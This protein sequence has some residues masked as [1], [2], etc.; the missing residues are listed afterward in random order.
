MVL[1]LEQSKCLL[2]ASLIY[3]VLS[4]FLQLHD[5]LRLS[6]ATLSTRDEAFACDVQDS[7]L[8]NMLPASAMMFVSLP[9]YPPRGQA[10]HMTQERVPPQHLSLSHPSTSTR[11]TNRSLRNEWGSSPDPTLSPL[12]SLSGVAATMT[13]YPAHSQECLVQL[14]EMAD[15]DADVTRDAVHHTEL[16]PLVSWQLATACVAAALPLPDTGEVTHDAAMVDENRALSPTMLDS[17]AEAGTGIQTSCCLSLLD[18]FGSCRSLMSLGSFGQPSTELGDLTPGEFAAM[19]AVLAPDQPSATPLQAL[20]SCGSNL[21]Q[22]VYDALTEVPATSVTQPSFHPIML[23]DA[24][25]S[26]CGTLRRQEDASTSL[27]IAVRNTDAPISELPLGAGWVP[28]ECSLPDLQ[29]SPPALSSSDYSGESYHSLPAVSS[30]LSDARSAPLHPQQLFQHWSQAM[31]FH[32]AAGPTAVPPLAMDQQGATMAQAGSL[33]TSAGPAIVAQNISGGR[34]RRGRAG[35]AAAST[36]ALRNREKQKQ[37]E[38][39]KRV[40]HCRICF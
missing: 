25:G 21:A 14:H 38:A 9:S 23:Q 20:A 1:A 34:R 26:F 8:L 39:R 5:N 16:E 2:R 33:S 36:R 19:A 35:E 30:D 40:R 7:D 37:Y 15:I 28:C 24:E 10:T 27:A 6:S 31:P 11:D 32:Q 22:A 18:T 12:G 29:D 17:I 13:Q 3:F 4:Q